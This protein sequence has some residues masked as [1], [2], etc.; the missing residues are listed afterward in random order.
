M[1]MVS[2]SALMDDKKICQK[3]CIEICQYC[4]RSLLE[5]LPL[6]VKPNSNFACYYG[7]STT[8][9]PTTIAMPG[10][11]PP[12]TTRDCGKTVRKSTS[13]R[14]PESGRADAQSQDVNQA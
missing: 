1:T 3:A 6:S 12:A 9:T 7:I 4:A 14:P 2:L 10:V 13:S 11:C 8:P 5:R